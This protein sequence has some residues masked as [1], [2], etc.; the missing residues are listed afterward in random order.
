MVIYPFLWRSQSEL[1]PGFTSSNCWDRQRHNSIGGLLSNSSVRQKNQM[2]SFCWGGDKL[3][4][5]LENVHQ[6]YP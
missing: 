1:D 4:Y 3:L 5:R 6:F 2:E